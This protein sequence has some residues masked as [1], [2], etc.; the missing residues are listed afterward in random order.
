MSG[1]AELYQRLR[2]PFAVQVP[3]N[4]N[5]PLGGWEDT[6]MINGA[7]RECHPDFFATPIGD[8]PTR[9][10]V[11]QRKKNENGMPFESLRE[12]PDT[13]VGPTPYYA[14]PQGS[15]PKKNHTE[16]E[17]Y[18]KKTA[19]QDNKGQDIGCDGERGMY[20]Q[21][22]D[23]YSDIPNKIPTRHGSVGGT[24]AQRFS[25]RRLPFQAHLQGVDY[26]RDCIRYRGIGIE[27]IDAKPGD[28]GYKENK[29]YFSAPPA[30]FDLSMSVQ[31]FPLWKREQL[32]QGTFTPERMAKLEKEHTFISRNPTF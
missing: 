6:Y 30:K 31:A 16:D 24:N 11:C 12:N 9:F 5:S 32:L 3:I 17:I 23:L 27:N 14:T 7:I 19:Y 10:L 2:D 28:F 26:Y 21:N 8:S 18:R 15:S 29:Y 20:V 22:Y 1:S 13:F 4:S 25:D